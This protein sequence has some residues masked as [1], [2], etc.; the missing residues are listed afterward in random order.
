MDFRRLFGD[1]NGNG[2]LDFAEFSGIYFAQGSRTGDPQY[3]PAFDF[4]NDGDVDVSDQL[5]FFQ[6]GRFAQSSAAP[7]MQYPPVA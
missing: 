6:G 1:A 2:R 3:N 4:D 5:A 7:P